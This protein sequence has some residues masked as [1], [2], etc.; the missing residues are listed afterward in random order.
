M[1]YARS[2]IRFALALTL[3]A[4]CSC[5]SPAAS[6]AAGSAKPHAVSEAPVR[7]IVSLSPSTT[8]AIYAIGAGERL[9]ARSA[10]CDFPAKAKTLPSVGGFASPDVERVVGLR[11]DWVVGSQGPAG[12]ALEARLRGLKIDTFFPPTRSLDDIGS[13]ITK[14][15]RRL[16]LQA[17]SAALR[18][19]IENRIKRIEQWAAKR[20]RVSVVLVF[21]ASP[22]FVAGPG[23]FSDELLRRAGAVNLVTKGGAYPNIDLEKLMALDPSLIIDASDMGSSGPSKLPSQPGWKKLRAVRE[24]NV[25]R[26]RSDSAMRP[27]PRIA[28]GLAKLATLIHKAEPPR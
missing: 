12:P 3:L 17:A 15:G 25:R 21:D 6:R 28:D 11:P 14:L 26:L 2:M 9:V 18:K 24:K 23:G 1:R 27:G 22:L 10:Q 4:L 19:R 5:D 20:P 8:E 7:R 16:Q 13:M